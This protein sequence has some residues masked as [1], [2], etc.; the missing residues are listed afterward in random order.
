[1]RA[2]YILC[3]IC[4]I[5]VNGWS[6]NQYIRNDTTICK[7]YDP[8]SLGIA[9]PNPDHCYRWLSFADPV[10]RSDPNPTANPRMTL[11]YFCQITDSDLSFV[12]EERVKVTVS[13]GQISVLGEPI[14]PDPADLESQAYLQLHET[15][16]EDVVWTIEADPDATG[17][18]LGSSVDLSTIISNCTNVGT[19]TVRATDANDPECYI[20][21]DIDVG[22][23]IIEL[24][25]RDEDDPDRSAYHD[26]TL[27]VVGP[28]SI[29]FTALTEAESQLAEGHPEWGGNP[30]P[31]QADLLQWVAELTSPGTYTVTCSGLTVT[32]IVL[33]DEEED[34]DIPTD[35]Q[36][37]IAFKDAVSS[38]APFF[39][40]ACGGSPHVEINV[41]NTLRGTK[42][43]IERSASPDYFTEIRVQ[44]DQSSNVIQSE[45]CGLLEYSKSYSIPGF[46]SF[47]LEAYIST[48]DP[49]L[50]QMDNQVLLVT[51]EETE[52]LEAADLQF[53]GGIEINVFPTITGNEVDV[54]VST[55]SFPVTS[56]R[57]S[58]ELQLD[59]E[60]INYRAKW[61]GLQM[62]PKGYMFTGSPSNP[63]WKAP[64]QFSHNIMDGK[65]TG[66]RTYAN[67]SS[68]FD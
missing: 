68:L 62:N 59:G 21:K 65:Q 41:D 31:E 57:L 23:G 61:G 24:I 66:W 64:V 63:V 55:G 58:A 4:V 53:T 12:A 22:P 17:C 38:L 28:S 34:F 11:T 39:P 40:D 60:Q 67:L 14:I 29:G 48:D 35:L 10:M 27:Y 50:T 32:V 18:S 54:F 43:Y 30:Q 51:D 42:K 1:M 33:T 2:Y 20:D 49:P 46:G 56:S 7:P 44:Q 25:A 45:G 52:E 19:I 6:Q 3:C 8:V 5:A 13:M 36:H 26:E 15:V 16:I 47:S 37:W 9:N